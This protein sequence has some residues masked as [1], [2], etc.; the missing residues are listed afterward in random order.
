MS[1]V[2][3]VLNFIPQHE[4]VGPYVVVQADLILPDDDSVIFFISRYQRELLLV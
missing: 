4:E 3:L 2:T 1:V